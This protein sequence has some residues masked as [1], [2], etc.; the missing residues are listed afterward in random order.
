MSVAITTAISANRER[1][2]NL[3]ED[4]WVY[5]VCTYLQVYKKVGLFR[6][7]LIGY[8]KDFNPNTFEY[9]ITNDYCSK[10]FWNTA[11]DDVYSDFYYNIVENLNLKYA[12]QGYTFKV[13]QVEVKYFI[14]YSEDGSTITKVYPWELNENAPREPYVTYSDS[15]IQE[16]KVNT[17]IL[18]ES[19]EINKGSN[20]PDT[21]GGQSAVDYLDTIL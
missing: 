6:R 18:L 8:V 19:V 3:R 12:K 21:A 17:N 5:R 15:D 9:E 4:K 11:R 2:Q 7:N 20:K 10:E 1:N 14:H 13:K 16:G